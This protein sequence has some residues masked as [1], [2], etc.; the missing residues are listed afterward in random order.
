MCY[1]HLRKIGQRSV[2]HICVRL[3]RQVSHTFVLDLC[4]TRFCKGLTQ[5]AGEARQCIAEITACREEHVQVFWDMTL[6]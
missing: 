2:T 1:T 5:A 3:G 4:Y 6:C